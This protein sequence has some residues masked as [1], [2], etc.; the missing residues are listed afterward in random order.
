MMN[1]ENLTLLLNNSGTELAHFSQLFFFTDFTRATEPW[2]E[3]I[4]EI[5][6]RIQVLESFPKSYGSDP[7]QSGYNTELL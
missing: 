6:A 7:Y 1:Y 2:F 4:R 3:P 5:L